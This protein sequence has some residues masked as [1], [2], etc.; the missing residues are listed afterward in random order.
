MNRGFFKEIFDEKV[1][2]FAI[3]KMLMQVREV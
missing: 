2:N 1:G 3:G